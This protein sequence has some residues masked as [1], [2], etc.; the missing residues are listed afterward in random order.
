MKVELPVRQL[1]QSVQSVS[2]STQILAPKFERCDS[3][4]KFA[5]IVD[6]KSEDKGSFSS[7]LNLALLVLIFIQ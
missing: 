6:R 7:L 1:K 2:S 5:V 3:P 4:L